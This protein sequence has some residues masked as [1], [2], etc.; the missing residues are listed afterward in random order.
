MKRGVKF[1]LIIGIVLLIGIFL[2][3]LRK[4]EGFKIQKLNVDYVPKEVYLVGTI[5]N[6]DDIYQNPPASRDVYAKAF[7]YDDAVQICKN[8]GGELATRAQL[9][10]AVDLSGHWCKRGWIKDDR[11]NA[12]FPSPIG[13]ACPGYSQGGVADTVVNGVIT[14][15]GKPP[16]G[17]AIQTATDLKTGASQDKAFAICYGPKPSLSETR[18]VQ[19]FN[20]EVYSMFDVNNMAS[21]VMNGPTPTVGVSTTTSDSVPL[22][23]NSY[24]IYP[25]TFTRAQALYALSQQFSKQFLTPVPADAGY[26]INKA[27]KILTDG[28]DTAQGSS[29]REDALNKGITT[30]VNPEL[31]EGD[32]DATSWN[33]NSK[34]QSCSSLSTFADTVR[35]KIKL[36][37]T[38]F[39]DVSGMTLT[40]I[41]MKTENGYLQSV[42]SDICRS[43]AAP[44]E[45][46]TRLLALDYDIFYRD[47]TIYS[48]DTTQPNALLPSYLIDD[49]ESLNFA[50]A[51]R[52]CE[53]QQILGSL[54]YLN[55]KLDCKVNFTSKSTSSDG[56]ITFTTDPIGGNFT[57]NRITYTDKNGEELVKVPIQCGQILDAG[58]KDLAFKVGRDVDYNAVERLKKSFEQISPYYSNEQFTKLVNTILDRLNVILEPPDHTKFLKYDGI[59]NNS[60]RNLYRIHNILL[61][62]DYS[63]PKIN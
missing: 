61:N 7:V 37:R 23:Y 13:D 55:D 45:A 33:T 1:L 58:E 9:Q 22:K 31:Y 32:A 10:M 21:Y 40:A 34:S 39:S 56:R 63:I 59:F 4:I 18:D 43:N 46:C 14:M 38:I 29:A 48:T 25:T 44:T 6:P 28:T 51:L 57:T 54:E 36:L 19:S 42:V 8:Y 5:L 60:L 16:K 26:D 47:R 53:L 20:K 27:R 30:A 62:N 24:N 2:W 3:S 35:D 15:K 11:T 49:L 52:E 50:L 41:Q 12:Y 17:R